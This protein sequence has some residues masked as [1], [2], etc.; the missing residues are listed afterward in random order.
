MLPKG[1]SVNSFIPYDLKKYFR[2]PT[3]TENDAVFAYHFYRILQRAQHI[4]LIYNTENNEL[5]SGEKSRFITQLLAEYKVGPIRSTIY[6][7]EQLRLT[8]DTGICIE[9]KGLEDVIC[10][11]AR[12]GVSPSALNRYTRCSLAFYYHYLANITEEDEVNEFA[13]ASHLGNA[14]HNALDSCYKKGVLDAELINEL[15]P[16][17]LNQLVVEFEVL[18]KRSS[19]KEGKN[20]LSVE[21]AKQLLLNF[22]D[23]EIK[24]VLKAKKDGNQIKIKGLEEKLRGKVTVNNTIFNL[25]GRVDRVVQLG[26][27]LRIIDYKTGK[28]ERL[29]VTFFEWKELANNKKKGKAFQLLM[30]AYLYLK[31]NPQYLDKKVVAGNFSFKNLKEGLICVSRNKKNKEGKKSRQNEMLQINKKVLRKFEEQ[32]KDILFK[33]QSEDFTQTD[34]L[35][36][37]EWCEY[38]LICK[39]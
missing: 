16:I 35:N 17:I 3:F 8:S 37:C 5:G 26:D 36:E 29:D 19:L 11:W 28:V 18:L 24:E 4:T 33:I 25:K 7:G 2:L 6:K 20:Y 34:D 38:K 14:I 32:L 31:N 30:Y 9:N 1:K 15:K 23:M 22:L 39:R 13:D 27:V 12:E 21:I 10:R